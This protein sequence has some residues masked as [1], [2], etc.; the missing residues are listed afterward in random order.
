MEGIRGGRRLL[1]GRSPMLG[2]VLNDALHVIGLELL[3]LLHARGGL[4]RL[5]LV[6]AEAPHEILEIR[7]ALL[8]ARVLVELL[9][10]RER[11]RF[12]V[13]VV[14][15]G[16]DADAAVVDVRHVRAHA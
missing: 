2:R 13:V 5:R 16:I 6:R 9:L 15:P 12:H 3:D 10:L 11:R 1:A 7:D 8:G 4:A 14:A